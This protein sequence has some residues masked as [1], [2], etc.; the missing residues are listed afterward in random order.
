MVQPHSPVTVYDRLSQMIP[1]QA[2]Q[3]HGAVRGVDLTNHTVKI[4][5][6]AVFLLFG[7][8]ASA[9]IS[10]DPTLCGGKPVPGSYAW[11]A[12]RV[13]PDRR[14]GWTPWIVDVDGV[15]WSWT[16]DTSAAFCQWARSMTIGWWTGEAIKT[17]CL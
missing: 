3:L 15:Q 11:I 10:D 7:G 12:P 13:D 17:E 16:F 9:E 14:V 1:R 2:I 6:L 4:L 5:T 8:T